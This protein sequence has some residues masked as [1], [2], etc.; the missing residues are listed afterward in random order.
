MHRQ[1]IMPLKGLQVDH[2]NGNGLDNRKANLRICTPSQNGCNRNRISRS[3]SG[4]KGVRWLKERCNWRAEIGLYSRHY[5]LGS[6]SSAI[7]AA[8]AYDKAARELHGEF[9]HLN[10]PATTAEA[11]PRSR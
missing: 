3:Q 2:I 9:A 4:F 11:I 6:F 7:E 1:L 8:L 10:F 5:N